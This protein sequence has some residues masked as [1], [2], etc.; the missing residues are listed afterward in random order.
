V[1]PSPSRLERA[2]DL[3]AL[4]LQTDFLK[5]CEREGNEGSL[6][7]DPGQPLAGGFNVDHARSLM[8]RTDTVE[9]PESKKRIVVLGDPHGDLIA[10]I[11]VLEREDRPE[12][13]IFSAGD[14]IGYADGPTSSELCRLLQERKIP[15]VTGNHEAWSK[16]G[17]LFLGPAPTQLTPEADAF[18]KGLPYRLKI[19]AK[20]APELS[21]VLVHTVP[22]WDY[23]SPENARNFS[24]TEGADIVFSG[25]THRPGVYTITDER[26]SL[27]NASLSPKKSPLRVPMTKG[28]RYIAD[29]GSIARPNQGFKSQLEKGSY[30]ALDLEKRV[31]EIHAFSKKERIEALMKR[32]VEENTK[33][34]REKKA[35]RGPE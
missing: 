11:E 21:L 8:E 1:V 2:R 19:V 14:N 13:Q 33:A 16:D 10:M 12:V 28:A 3:L 26:I 29:A 31:L 35:E 17:K 7:D 27:E 34:A 4:E 25:H 30:A 5:P 20:A 32:V 22:N 24:L 9:L 15:S 18:C 6:L 23:V